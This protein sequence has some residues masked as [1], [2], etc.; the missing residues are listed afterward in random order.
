MGIGA[1]VHVLTR[2]VHPSQNIRDK[3]PNQEKGSRLEGCVVTGKCV[4]KVS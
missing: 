2:F 1:V 4:K 3:Y